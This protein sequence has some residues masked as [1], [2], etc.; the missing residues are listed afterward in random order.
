M[1]LDTETSRARAK[2]QSNFLFAASLPVPQRDI[3]HGLRQH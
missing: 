1:A 3:L 2:N